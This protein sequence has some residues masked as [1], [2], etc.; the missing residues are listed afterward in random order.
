MKYGN[1]AF[2]PLE[3]WANVPQSCQNGPPTVCAVG[4][5]L[6]FHAQCETASGAALPHYLIVRFEPVPGPGETAQ[7]TACNHDPDPPM[8]TGS[9]TVTGTPGAFHVSG[10]C[11]CTD[12]DFNA[13][14]E[15][16]FS[17]PLSGA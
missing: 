6:Q 7:C 10:Q 4:S 9:A 1:A 12:G 15:V 2:C 14:V 11:T 5:W 3:N 8:V 13:T 17:L 16:D